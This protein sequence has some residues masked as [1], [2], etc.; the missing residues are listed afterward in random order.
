M[1]KPTLFVTH[2]GTF[3]SDELAASAVLQ[4][5]FGEDIPI[6]RTRDNLGDYLG[7]SSVIVYDV[8]GV[9]DAPSLNF[10]HHQ[11]E[12][13]GFHPSGVPYASFG[14]VW[15]KFGPVLCTRALKKAK[16]SCAKHYVNRLVQAIR[17]S[18]VEYIDGMDNG[19]L[20][21]GRTSLSGDMTYTMRSVDLAT[22]LASFIPEDP[23]KMDEGF[24]AALAV[25]SH[26]LKA[27]IAYQINLINAEVVVSKASKVLP[28]PS[29]IVLEESV[30]WFEAVLALPSTAIS[31][32]VFP[33]RHDDTWVAQ[34]VPAAQGSWEGRCAFP[35]PWRGLVDKELC[36]LTDTQDAVFCHRSGFLVRT[37]SRASAISLATQAVALADTTR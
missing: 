15:N 32:C 24:H 27:Q 16:V 36:D 25:V 22:V 20:S 6:L 31:F 18:L 14:L 17:L 34:Q 28:H 29:V 33:S 13:A 3:H 10:D 21:S 4:A 19:A 5:V 1:K 8:G 35:E 2:S 9:Y 7:D 30:P 26:L 37:G 11:R 12:G 23:A